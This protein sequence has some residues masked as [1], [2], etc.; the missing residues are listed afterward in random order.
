MRP[1]PLRHCARLLLAAVL[2]V[3]LAAGA[4]AL[5]AA[6][7]QAKTWLA[8][9][10]DPE[11]D[12]TKKLNEFENRILIQINKARADK[13]LKKVRVF[14]SCVDKRSERWAGRIK[15]T[16]EFVHR[17]QMKVLKR[18]DLAWTGETLVRGVGLTPES[19]V[20][21][22]LNSPSHYDVIMKKRARWAGIGVRVDS[23]GRV[24]GVLNFGDRH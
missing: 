6:P 4:A 15:R 1:T 21:A 17:D 8:P 20:N 11:V 19:A 13:G 22:W 10:A 14:Q 23:D 5:V 7:A 9:S 18:C 2:S 16:G 12:P 24:V 3:A